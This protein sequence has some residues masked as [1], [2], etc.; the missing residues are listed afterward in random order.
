MTREACNRPRVRAVQAPSADVAT[1]DQEVPVRPRSPVLAPV[2]IALALALHPVCPARAQ[3]A[4]PAQDQPDMT[5]DTAVRHAVLDSLIAALNANY[6]FPAVARDLERELRR[7]ERGGAFDRIG[8]A[9]AFADTLTILLRRVGHDRHFRVG[10]RYEPIPMLQ[11]EGPPPPEELRRLTRQAERTNFGFERAERLAGNIGYLEVR[12]FAPATPAAGAA[13]VAAMNLLA[14][15]DALIID[16]R[17]NGGGSPEM[18]AL[19]SSYLFPD[20]DRTHLNDLVMRDG[21]HEREEQYHT[22]PWVPGS[23]YTGKEVFVLTSARTGSAAEEFSYNLKN[24]ARATLVGDTTIGAAN[25]G[26]FVRLSEHFAAFISN[27]RARNPI[28]HTNWEGSGVLPD[29][30]CSTDS[31]LVVAH[32]SALEHLIAKSTDEDEKRALGRALEVA[33]AARVEPLGDLR[34][35]AR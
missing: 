28:S 30:P 27:G 35:P 4:P 9:E 33:K 14:H 18:V 17:R 13:A 20:D 2:W 10:Y 21:G 22:L 1:F 15:T 16:V 19:L 12:Q 32:V 11:R 23:R 29:L 34:A 3:L 26:G 25:P 24:L 6:V 8:S 7:R 31:A 5:V